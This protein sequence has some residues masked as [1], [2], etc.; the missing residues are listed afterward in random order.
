[1]EEGGSSHVPPPLVS[2][3]GGVVRQNKRF[4]GDVRQEGQWAEKER[5]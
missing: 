4:T 3:S 2:A 5:V 1:M